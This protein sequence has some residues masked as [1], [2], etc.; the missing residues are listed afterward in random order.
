MKNTRFKLQLQSFLIV[1]LT[2]VFGVNANAQKLTVSG[3]VK[4]DT[5]EPVIGASV[6]EKGT[7]NGI[8]TNVEGQFTLS[9]PSNSTLVVSY[10]GYKTQ[11]IPVTGQTTINVT[12]KEDTKMLGE[13]VA[14]GYGTV[15]KND[16]TGSVTAISTEKMNKG[17][18][19]SFT[20]MLGGKMAGVTVTTSGGTP[21]AGATIRIRGGSSLKASNDPLYVIDG[22]PIDGKSVN[23]SSNPLSEI[24]PQ[25]IETFTVL[26]DASATA[27]YGSRASNGVILITTK[28]GK[29]NQKMSISYDG[30]ASISTIG[31][32]IDVLNADEYKSF[33]NSNYD[34]SSPAIPLLGQSSTNWQ[35]QIF[36]EAFGQNHHLSLT[37]SIGKVLPF[38]ASV[39]YTNQDG[40]LKT[41]NFKR[42]TGTLN[43]TP[44]LLNDHLKLALN[45]NGSY[46][47]NRFADTGAIGAAIE[48]DPTQSVYEDSNYGNGYFMWLKSSDNSPVDIAT[49][50]PL[51]VLTE[52]KDISSVYQ[53][54]GNFQADYA[55][56]GFEALKAHLNIAYDFSS[57]NGSLT[58]NENS[59]MSW[60]W[61]NKKNGAG[62]YK[63]YAQS[64]SNKLLEF[65]MNYAKDF[66]IHNIDMMA[67]YSYQH[68]YQ[69]S[70]EEITYTD[71]ISNQAKVEYPSE[72]FLIS[73]YGR[74]NYSLLDKYLLT[75]TLRDDGSSR[76]AP[77]N[78]WGLF[79][80]AAF[81]WKIKEESF[82]KNVDWINE[83]KLRLGYGIT[84][85]QNIDDNYYNYI[86]TYTASTYD[87][88]QYQF[89]DNFYHVLR[90]NSLNAGLKWESTTTYNIGL[91][92]GAYQNRFT[93]S[94]D[95]Y[96]R[97]TNDLLNTIPVAA[98]QN[99]TNRLLTNIGSL[100]NKGVE[101]TLGWY[102]VQ[103]NDISW[104]VNYTFAYNHNEITKLTRAY[105]PSYEGVDDG[106]INGGTGN[107]IYM[108]QVG[109]PIRSFYVYKQLYDTN[110]NPIEGAYENVGTSS[111]KYHYYSPEPDFVM[112]FSSRFNYHNWY[113][114]F[115]LRSNIGNYVYNNVRSNRE[116]ISDSY[117]SAGFL[118]NILT[119]GVST[120][121]STAQY[122]SDYYV[123]N[124]SFVKV[125]NITVGYNFNNLFGTRMRGTIYHTIQNP[126]V[127]TKYSG[128]D[129]EVETGID[130]NVYPRPIIF[131]LG[132][133]LNM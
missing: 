59:P 5:G 65:Y 1:V 107:K 92:F 20:D 40:I 45:A 131:L 120:N 60:V 105:D 118:K 37:G 71:N 110:G 114:N 106:S 22:I 6:V 99:F 29:A 122:M 31:K 78:R 82:L 64:K 115:S 73:F 91:D 84:G 35:K 38:R 52:K 21:G 93:A 125:D 94:L 75:L 24:N 46:S 41:S 90:P 48:F 113:F 128:I 72:L 76:F 68:F 18:A 47:T 66:G 33:I 54:I 109:Y 129:P 27:I 25:D 83:F 69:N 95:A 102:P 98:G 119:S 101:L 127:L 58:I 74:L 2:I 104:N 42:Y 62:E 121:F 34:T 43:F 4:D 81:A 61:G 3:T 32:M 70:W 86:A 14:I 96:K 88:V 79:P 87:D 19:T 26:K 16:A 50:N 126:F 51:S 17:L 8:V 112:G 89:G 77:D 36:S 116:V 15:K 44:S 123:E 53:G 100:E 108:N 132:L 80:S 133:K 12:M 49:C 39:G 11:E 56:H 55:V 10:I 57:S 103:L 13:V 28:R 9:V 30:D 23:G 85:Q 111:N 67:G 63:N 97:V 130:N 7:T 124:A 117:N